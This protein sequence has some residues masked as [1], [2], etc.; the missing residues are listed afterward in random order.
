SKGLAAN[1]EIMTDNLKSDIQDFA[2]HPPFAF[3]ARQFDEDGRLLKDAKI[4]RVRF[5]EQGKQRLKPSE[6]H[7]PRLAGYNRTVQG[8][9]RLNHYTHLNKPIARKG[10]ND[11]VQLSCESCHVLALDGKRMQKITFADHCAGC[12]QQRDLKI[13]PNADEKKVAA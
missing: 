12:H 1:K 9:I 2:H 11:K 6:E 10:D 3:S 7:D 8:A 5:D 13:D 4:E